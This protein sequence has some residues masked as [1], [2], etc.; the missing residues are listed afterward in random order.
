MH[1]LVSVL[2]NVW[3]V[4]TDRDPSALANVCSKCSLVS[5]AS[6]ASLDVRFFQVKKNLTLTY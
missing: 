2:F 1:F 3:G 6:L 5:F 4:C